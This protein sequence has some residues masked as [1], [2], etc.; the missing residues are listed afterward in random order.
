MIADNTPI[1][2]PKLRKSHDGSGQQ[3]GSGATLIGVRYCEMRADFAIEE[4]KRHLREGEARVARQK[5]LIAELERDGHETAQAR[6]LLASFEATL[7]AQHHHMN[8]MM[9]R[10]RAPPGRG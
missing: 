10:F 6:D 8:L 7:E 4:G 1:G 5:E 3:K 2:A 9:R